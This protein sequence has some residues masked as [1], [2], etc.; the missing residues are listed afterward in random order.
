M[1]KAI[2]TSEGTTNSAPG[3]PGE[4]H[5]AARRNKAAC[6]ERRDFARQ[7]GKDLMGRGNSS[8]EVI[9]IILQYSTITR[10]IR[11]LM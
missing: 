1:Q 10:K 3:S 5:K 8:S 6:E 11:Y 4:L 2:G 9:I 7:R